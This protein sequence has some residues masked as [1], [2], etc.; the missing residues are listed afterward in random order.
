MKVTV[1]SRPSNDQ[2][3]TV[4]V[5]IDNQADDDLANQMQNL[6]LQARPK[7]AAPPA[8]AKAKTKATP[9]AA[10][11]IA[12]APQQVISVQ[13][14]SKVVWAKREGIWRNCKWDAA[15]NPDGL[16]NLHYRLKYGERGHEA[17]SDSQFEDAVDGSGA[18]L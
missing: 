7:P 17:D 12:A 4:V 6:D 10:P 14:C 13:K 3:V 2:E 9:K 8:A 16:C 18:G 15:N 11:K 1:K 5:E